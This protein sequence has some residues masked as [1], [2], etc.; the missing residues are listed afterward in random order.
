MNAFDYAELEHPAAPPLL[1]PV[2]AAVGLCGMLLFGLV[3][4]FSSR[5]EKIINSDSDFIPK[6]GYAS[7]LLKPGPP[8]LQAIP[9]SILQEIACIFTYNRYTAVSS[10]APKFNSTMTP[11]SDDGMDKFASGATSEDAWVYGAKMG[12]AGLAYASGEPTDVL[13][14]RLLC[15]D[16]QY[17]PMKLRTADKFWGFNPSLPEKRELKRLFL[18][19]VKQDGTSAK[20]YGFFLDAPDPPV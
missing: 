11:R 1:H 19:A 2:R 9:P 18:L 13:K 4:H 17:F 5:G 16:P 8:L 15:W 3:M 20:A 12:N 6:D 10:G 14:G 7:V